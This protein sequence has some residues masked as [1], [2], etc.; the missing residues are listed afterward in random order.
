MDEAKRERL[1]KKG[2]HV[3]TAAEFLGLTSIEDGL[4]K[5]AVDASRFVRERRK[6]LGLTQGE[7]AR[8][9]GSTQS[10]VAKLENVA[11]G[12]SLDLYFRAVFALGG[13]VDVAPGEAE[14]EAAAPAKEVRKRPATA[15]RESA[16]GPDGKVAAK[17]R[18]R[19]SVRAKGK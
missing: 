16:P 18:A 14:V 10:R 1:G 13:R 19:V 11:A 8:R 3:G 6:A 17:G 7:L 5:L 15:R 4:I 2:W 12:T 9:I